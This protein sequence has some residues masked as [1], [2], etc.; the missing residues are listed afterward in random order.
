MSLKIRIKAS[1]NLQYFPSFGHLPE[2][3]AVDEGLFDQE[4][5]EIEYIEQNDHWQIRPAGEADVE[6]FNVFSRH[7]LFEQSESDVV[8]ACEAGNLR[9]AYDSKRGGRALSR[10]ESP[11]NQALITAPGSRF[12]H[13]RS[14]AQ[15]P[16]AVR[17]HS[18]SHYSALELLEGA[19]KREDIKLVNYTH[20]DGWNAVLSGEAAAVTLPEPWITLARKKGFQVVAETTMHAIELGAPTVDPAA[21][22]AYVRG[23]RKAVDRLNANP[24]LY[25]KRYIDFIVSP[26]PEQFRGELT[27]DD[28]YLPKFR[29]GGPKP[30]TEQEF[31]QTYDWLVSWDLIGTDAGYDRLVHR[32]L[33]TV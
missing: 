14:L 21:Y 32:D 11:S 30:Y 28:F 4:D 10:V 2:R 16:V 25:F 5:L 31:Q 27:A 20:L 12:T 29:W 24:A 18:G 1:H 19:V 3:I 15:Q 9:R 7:Y 8:S 33:A 6:Q 17:F 22:A 13:P 26:L 23:I